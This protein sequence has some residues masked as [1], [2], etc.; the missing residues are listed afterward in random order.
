MNAPDL[1]IVRPCPKW[2]TEDHAAQAGEDRDHHSS[3]VHELRMPNGRL[4]AE[5]WLTLEPRAALP[6]LVVSGALDL[7]ADDVQLLG[8]EEARAF[9]QGVQ[10]FASHVQRM[11]ELLR[12]AEARAASSRPR[13]RKKRPLPPSMQY[14]SPETRLYLAERDGRRCF[15]CRTPFDS[16]RDATMDHYVPRSLWACNMPANLVLSCLPCNQAKDDRLTWSMAA[17][18]LAW[19]AGEGGSAGEAETADLPLPAAC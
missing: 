16:L 1:S 15:Y 19:Q 11:T 3:A 14:A 12:V 7:V 9:D 17:V 5:A 18:L 6:Q 2:C 4:A 8:A 13:K 10:R